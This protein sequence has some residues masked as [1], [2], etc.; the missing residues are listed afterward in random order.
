MAIFSNSVRNNTLQEAAS[1]WQRRDPQF[2][3]LLDTL[4]QLLYSRTSGFLN[5]SDRGVLEA[6]T[7]TAQNSIPGLGTPM[8]DFAAVN[9]ALIGAGG[10]PL[11]HIDPAG[12][13]SYGGRAYGTGFVSTAATTQML[14]SFEQ[15]MRTSSGRLD[16]GQTM[17]LSQ[18]MRAQFMAEF[19]SRN[20]N[21]IKDA[22]KSYDL[23]QA[24]DQ[25]SLQAQIGKMRTAGVTSSSIKALE[26]VQ[27]AMAYLSG[28]GRYG[29][30]LAGR[31]GTDEFEMIAS[32]RASGKFEEST[33]QQTISQLKGKNTNY[34]TQSQ[35]L[36]DAVKEAYKSVGENLKDLSELFQTDDLTKIQSYAKAIGMGSV[37]TKEDAVSVR[38]QMREIAAI[39]AVTGRSPQ[40]V[41]AERVQ[42]SS[43]LS[44]MFGGRAAHHDM[45]ST[46]TSAGDIARLNGNEG[47]YS[48]EASQTAAAKSIANSHNMMR[49]MIQATG[50]VELMGGEGAMTEEARNRYRALKAA[51]E[52]AQAAGD[53]DQI[54][55]I[56]DS[57][58][59]FARSTFGSDVVDN[60]Q[61]LNYASSGEAGANAARAHR[62]G[63]LRDN[64]DTLAR[65]YASGKMGSENASILGD[66]AYQ[67]IDVFGRDET[68]RNNF[69]AA[70]RKGDT[71]AAT[72]TL[73][74]DGGLSNDQAAA[75]LGNINK[76]GLDHVS[77]M[78]L[79][80]TAA[81]WM[82]QVSGRT[83]RARIT[84]ETMTN[85][86]GNDA[87]NLTS[88][89]GYSDSVR[90]F[91][92][93]M[94]KD[95]GLS[96][97]EIADLAVGDI[98]R[99]ASR[100]ATSTDESVRAKAGAEAEK[101]EE[102]LKN[103]K[104]FR[105]G[106][107]DART[108]SFQLGA[109]DRSR[110]A[111]QLG[112]SEEE[113]AALTKDGTG[114]LEFLEKKGMLISNSKDTSGKN[115]MAVTKEAIDDQRRAY[116]DKMDEAGIADVVKALGEDAVT[117]DGQD[118]NI[119]WQ[120]QKFTKY[121]D[122]LK[123]MLDNPAGGGLMALSKLAM[124]GDS[125]AKKY[126]T[127][128]I[129]SS[130]GLKATKQGGALEKLKGFKN[131]GIQDLQSALIQDYG[132]DNLAAFDNINSAVAAGLADY[133]G[134]GNYRITERGKRALGEGSGG[135]MTE[136][137][138]TEALSTVSGNTK[139]LRDL[140]EG[141]VEKEGPTYDQVQRI[142][143]M[144]QHSHSN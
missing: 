90:M 51:M 128:S 86:L 23:S 126:L 140:T 98:F 99:Q 121:E 70:L 22:F 92:A 42:I 60:A 58:G 116:N 30:D 6:I 44:A 26:D 3:Q 75:L 115:V 89:S 43:G 83:D 144:M 138:L 54:I 108:N 107:Y 104:V 139:D 36:Q 24:T 1:S 111:K 110:L 32:L 29:D 62:A 61:F 103:S 114:Y 63:L 136:S 14:Q 79:R 56:S 82:Q 12:N 46:V 77:Q 76:V 67:L 122:V 48:A 132:T 91:V 11:T 31:V 80:L 53:Y 49:G 120:D 135:V 102:A 28:K 117:W 34:M 45:I 73:T 69:L 88:E 16:T 78:S 113:L 85:W 4:S 131:I 21:L 40:E 125:A 9:R 100:A 64:A 66:V 20:P 17:G 93:G 68:G 18:S 8:Q 71:N 81:D 57:M 7:A 25:Q 97:Q 35:Q 137:E 84:R 13:A 50:A 118:F 129:R 10:I 143:E 134:D 37:V 96:D 119:T 112:I 141:L 109:E 106:S 47:L 2:Q 105:I 130:I 27:S 74:G 33:I 124:G 101:A 65:K 38:S 123:A 142:L 52:K 95:G 87:G 41:A 133:M 94:M 19:I 55:A 15:S 72:E 39:A 5:Q 59:K 127:K